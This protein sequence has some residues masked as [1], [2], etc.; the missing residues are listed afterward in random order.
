M[1]W[2]SVNSRIS[3]LR[4]ELEEE[5]QHEETEGLEEGL[6]SEDQFLAIA[7]ILGLEPQE[8]AGLDEEQLQEAI[9]YIGEMMYKTLANFNP[10]H[11]GPSGYATPIYKPEH[12][13]PPGAPNELPS[14][15]G[16]EWTRKKGHKYVG[17]SA[18]KGKMSGRG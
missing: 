4:S 3:A 9:G 13:G 12:D 1:D 18:H 2:A 17:T 15:K 16:S 7:S 6:L 11:E 10:E 5:E 8:L 14:A